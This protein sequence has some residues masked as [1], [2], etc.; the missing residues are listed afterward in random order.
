[1]KRII[2][3]LLAV[4]LILQVM[5]VA[6]FSVSGTDSP[7]HIP[8]I[9]SVVFD[10]SGS[11]YNETDR[12]A[13]TSYAMQAFVAM[14]GEEDVLYITYLNAK[15]D[16]VKVTLSKSGKQSYIDTI[17]KAMFGGGTP[18]RLSK[19]KDCLV[20][21]Y[22]SYGKNA[23]YYLVVMADGSL[24]VGD[25]LE[26]LS[27][28]TK[29]AVNEL[30]GAD[31]ESVYF[32]MKGNLKV[33][34]VNNKVASSGNEIVEVL[35]E[36]S[37]DIM[38]RTIVKTA[39]T[40]GKISF[41][42]KY[43]ALSIAVFVQ[44][45]NSAFTNV[46]VPVTY[47]GKSASYEISTFYLDCPTKINKNPNHT[48]YQEKIPSSPPSGFVSLISNG[49][50]SISKGSYTIDFS[51]YNI[52]NSN[53]VVMVEP[54]VRIDCQYFIGDSTKPIS[55][56]QLKKDVREGD[57]V[58]VKC[59]LYEIN[60]DGS[61]GDAVPLDVLSPSYKLYVNDS[62]AGK[63][64]S[65]NE[66][67]YQ[68]T[69]TEDYADKELKIEAILK[70][71]QPFVLKENFGDI[72]F[73]PTFDISAGDANRT[74]NLTKPEWKKWVEGEE[75]IL[76]PLSVADSSMLG[77]MS[78]KTENADFLASGICSELKNV[79]VIGNSVEYS[80]VP[81]K[82]TAF[83]KLPQTFSI[84][85]HD[86]V[87]NS[88][89]GSV[90]VNVIQPQYRF[91]CTNELNEVSLGSET[92]KTN[93]KA[94]KFVLCADYSGNGVY[95]P[96]KDSDCEDNIKISLESGK[97]PGAV[98]EESGGI[99]FVPV[100]NVDSDT[101]VSPAE[102]LGKEHSVYA[103]AVVDGVTVNSEKVVIPVRNVSYKLTVSN[104]ITEPLN[105]STV[106]GNKKKIVFGLLADYAGDGK[107]GPVAE[108]DYG[109]F[110]KIQ[111]VSGDLPGKIN[112]ENDENGNPTGI[113]F[114]P[115]YDENNNNGIPFTKVAGKIHKITGALQAFDVKS[116][117]TVEV[118]A[119]V[120]EIKVQK[121]GITLVDTQIR[122]NEQGVEFVILRDER[123]L[124]KEELEGLAPYDLSFS[125]EQKWMSVEGAAMDGYLFCKPV[126]DGWKFI[127]PALWSWLCLFTVQKGDMSV[128]L[129]CGENTAAAAIHI[130]MS[131]VALT[132]FLVI[133][134]VLLLILWIVFCFVT[135]IRFTRGAFYKATLK[136]NSNGLGYTFSTVSKINIQ[137]GAVRNF[138]LGGKLFIPF[139]QQSKKIMLNSKSVL[140]K[141]VKA[142]GARHTFPYTN[143]S[144]EIKG[145]FNRGHLSRQRVREL[146]C[147]EKDKFSIDATTLKGKPCGK[148]K[149]RMV[150]GVFLIENTPRANI[151]V[152][153]VSKKNE[154]KMKAL[155]PKGTGSGK[156]SRSTRKSDLSGRRERSSVK[157]TKKSNRKINK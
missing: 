157:N 4:F 56:E 50:K 72:K 71:Y 24:D 75:K 122:K 149:F 91:D 85:L 54:A 53:V 11:M 84:L 121:E 29:E 93:T 124:T 40:G 103:T 125:T 48:K 114:T 146:V 144:G 13:Y 152:F 132:I 154:R 134:G 35:R 77:D 27:D 119:P 49:D 42:L 109:V 21:E 30:S 116:E 110:E 2:S 79:Q 76:F 107:F 68:L 100:Y 120:Y 51:S 38:G 78:I 8:R 153:Y 118:L 135:R 80:P 104:E 88:V 32:S 25:M 67:E 143:L 87:S 117:T 15:S 1:M 111:I 89:I 70:G 19:G 34:G 141:T 123:P 137:K 26:E 5:C 126:Y 98:T 69:V 92:L 28:V 83:D 138:I 45:T 133:I 86:D 128:I 23:K 16:P 18:N 55:F 129:K 17:E 102:V 58:R 156:K 90:K 66:N 20:T 64:L 62:P 63:K 113:S 37:A 22:A 96:I 43:P 61:S 31:F 112:R 46:K 10:D 39:G 130:D 59:G 106:N 95:T 151:I 147:R 145:E 115:D 94:V 150:T 81:M 57:N 33:P 6:A 142:S 101:K 47:N 7:K 74:L 3:V 108:W 14:M 44:K 99:S 140:F 105:L 9:V 155:A 41:D 97:L 65:G 82:Q 127:S 131:I 36:I 139:S 12:W 73:R 52:S 136:P 60:S 148:E